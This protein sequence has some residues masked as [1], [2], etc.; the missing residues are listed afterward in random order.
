MLAEEL[1]HLDDDVAV[2]RG[3]GYTVVVD[4]QATRQDLREAVAAE[5]GLA[6]AG[7]SPP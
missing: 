1:A 2:L 7:R 3:A 5:R 6:P 4:R